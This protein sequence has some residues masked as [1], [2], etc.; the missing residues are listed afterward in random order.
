M[1]AAHHSFV[2]EF[3]AAK[4]LHLS[5]VVEKFNFVN[6]HAEIFLL[7]GAEQWWIEAASPQA[8]L[9]RG[10]SKS[11]LR[12]GMRVEIEAYASKDGSRRGYG[13]SVALPG[14][15]TLLLNPS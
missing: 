15:R 10:V 14:G 7:V 6:P 5:G 12:E 9:R 11:T 8:L 4:P 1:L 13:R 3:D 2:A